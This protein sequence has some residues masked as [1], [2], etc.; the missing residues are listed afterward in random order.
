MNLLRLN[1]DY[2]NRVFGLD[3]MRAIAI[4]IVVMGHGRFILEKTEQN[5]SWIELP[6]GVDLFFVLSGFLIGGIL[7]R[8]F[9]SAPAFGIKEVF[10]FLKR[11]WF[12]T[13][14]NYYLILIL[15]VVFVYTG[16]IHEDFTKFNL[17]F[18]FFLQNFNSCLTGFFW[19]SWSLTT[20]EWFYLLFPHLLL[21]AW[22]CFGTK[23]SKKSLFGIALFLFLVIP[24]ILR[25]IESVDADTV[26]HFWMELKFRRVVL[27]RLD[28]IAFGIIGAF[29]KAYYSRFW[30]K[31]RYLL[32][33][34]GILILFFNKTFD[35]DPNT[36]YVQTFSASISG[37][38]ALLLLPLFD[39]MKSNKIRVFQKWVTHIS[40]I[41]YSMYLINLALVAEVIRDYFMPETMAGAWITYLIYWGVII[42]VSTLLYKNF[43]KPVMDLR[44]RKT[45]P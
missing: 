36:L 21:G 33:I 20:E 42:L 11:R 25:I 30:A 22:S 29:I 44:D 32:F 5:F 19:E 6:D 10:H 28:S 40:L 38:G 23:I 37:I 35:D 26:D 1:P 45:T 41:S 12:R 17:G 31:G 7:I 27:F 18:L 14:P 8:S 15:N 13:L 39:S 24:L 3:L 43:E 34:A 16:I 4:I 2:K 9:E